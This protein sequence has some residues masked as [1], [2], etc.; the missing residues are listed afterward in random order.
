VATAVFCLAVSLLPLV[1]LPVT[2]LRF[3]VNP[4]SSQ[5]AACVTTIGLASKAPPAYA[6][7]QTAEAAANLHQKQKMASDLATRQ[8]PW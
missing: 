4:V 8:K 5:V 3:P 2:S 6:E 7:P 1:G